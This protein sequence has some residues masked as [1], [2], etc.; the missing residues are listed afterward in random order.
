[1]TKRLMF[2]LIFAVAVAGLL[3]VLGPSSAFAS[4]CVNCDGGAG[5]HS[6]C[7]TDS[8]SHEFITWTCVPDPNHPS[9][10]IPVNVHDYGPGSC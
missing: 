2:S 3:V 5:D 10:L 6:I 9:T 4:T 7:C 8:P 1:M